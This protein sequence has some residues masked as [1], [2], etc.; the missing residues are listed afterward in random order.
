MN[1]PWPTSGGAA[2]LLGVSTPQ[3]YLDDNG[4][5]PFCS[6]FPSHYGSRI[7]PVTGNEFGAVIDTNRSG[8]ATEVEDKPCVVT[9][10]CSLRFDDGEV[11]TAQIEAPSPHQVCPVVYSG[12]VERLPIRDA[13]ADTVWLRVLFRSFARE[14]RAKYEE[15]V[16]GSWEPLQ[17]ED[18]ANTP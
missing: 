3:N 2:T 1:T 4:R 14:L 11:V 17:E 10:V 7:V 12:A 15:V 6:I 9:L 18:G 8:V 13:T 5:N 16:R